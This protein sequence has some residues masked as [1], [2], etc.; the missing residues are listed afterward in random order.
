MCGLGFK[1]V[2]NF[3]SKY[4]FL[5]I[6]LLFAMFLSVIRINNAQA[7]NREPYNSAERDAW[8]LCDSTGSRRGAIWFNN[9][10]DDINING[11]GTGYY[12]GSVIVNDYNATTVPVTVRGSVFSCRNIDF[13]ET[14]AIN[15]APSESPSRLS[16]LSSTDLYRGSVS[17]DGNW[18]TKGGSINATLNVA[19]IPNMSDNGNGYLVGTIQIGLD[20]C[21]YNQTINFVGDCYVQP[22][23]VTVF[24]KIPPP[25]WS[26]T[27]TANVYKKVGSLITGTNVQP[28]DE[29]YWTHTVTNNDFGGNGWINATDK[30]VTHTAVS[31]DGT[32]T[33]S[34]FAKINAGFAYLGQVSYFTGTTVNSHVSNRDTEA[35]YVVRQVDVGD[36][37]QLCRSTDIIPSAWDN[38]N[39]RNSGNACVNVPYNYQLTPTVTTDSDDVIEQGSEL[40]VKF[41]VRNNG[42][43]KSRPSIWNLRGFVYN[44]DGSLKQSYS[45]VGPVNNKVFESIDN[46]EEL[47]PYSQTVSGDYEAGS[48]I[49]FILTVSPQNNNI[50]SGDIDSSQ[51]C[52]VIGKKP[53][54]QIWGGDL[55]SRGKVQTSTSVKTVGANKYI[56]GSWV[57]YGIFT[58][59]TIIGLASGSAF[60]RLDYGWLNSNNFNCSYNKLSFTNVPSGGS[61][62]TGAIGGYNPTTSFPNIVN[63]YASAQKIPLTNTSLS[64]NSLDGIYQINNNVTLTG[65]TGNN[66]IP[67]NKTVILY[68]PNNTVTI[69]GNIEYNDTVQQQTINDIQQV[70]II[71]KFIEIKND[72]QKIDAWLIGLDH[73]NTCTDAGLTANLSINSC[74]NQ[75]T[76][77]GPVMTDKLYLRRT[78]GSNPCTTLGDCSPVG[79]PAEVFNLRAD[80]FL[81][82][83]AFQSLIG[84]R[85]QTVYTTELAPRF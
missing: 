67:T 66:K 14:Y 51:V 47:G 48:K 8:N 32:N 44:P 46:Y 53:K 83:V 38:V 13:A 7:Y 62:C 69:V 71:A 78:F 25:M 10:V 45:A 42:P 72:V 61:V 30:D 54:V 73:I 57:E 56:F 31:G 19:N 50:N 68:V 11:S 16:N 23:N 39:S 3:R 76:I 29:L 49:C 36:G 52:F 24:R 1:K 28:G 82:S 17:G 85:A 2:I 84:G 70:L 65:D 5:F 81:W 27:P 77:N 4:S 37:K 12:T 55:I 34:D 41:G 15:V 6:I 80:A 60:N 9:T 74:A 63:Y 64:L 18:S 20:R 59:N 40:R 75:L 33:R 43:T 58:K 26:L 35:G 79:V 21:F 22:V